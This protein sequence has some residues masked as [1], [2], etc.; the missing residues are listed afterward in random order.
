MA[1]S[2]V[3]RPIGHRHARVLFLS[4][5]RDQNRLVYEDDDDFLQPACRRAAADDAGRA[6]SKR[7]TVAARGS[8][9][10]CSTILRAR[11]R[12]PAPGSHPAGAG[13]SALVRATE[14]LDAPRRAAAQNH[15]VPMHMHL[16]ETAYQKEYARRRSGDSAVAHLDQLGL[17]GPRLTLGHGVWLTEADIE[18]IAATGDLHLPQLQLEP[19]AAQRHRAAQ[20]L[21]RRAASRS[22]SASTRPASTTTATCCRRCAWC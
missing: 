7:V 1:A 11:V 17:L 21:R 15:G 14:A 3:L 10:R 4:R 6:A 16:L 9:R 22:P 5:V 8:L 13:Q 18:L 12:R 19:P 20:R 2:A